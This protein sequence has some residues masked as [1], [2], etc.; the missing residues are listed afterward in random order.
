MRV[1]CRIVHGAAA[2]KRFS[3]RWDVITES[4]QRVGF[5]F[6]EAFSSGSVT[7]LVLL[8]YGV[9]LRRVH[10]SAGVWRITYGRR[11]VTA[12]GRTR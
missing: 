5:E 4:S 1:M 9:V 7:V 2:F 10:D 6:A 8:C 12:M 11:W 3:L